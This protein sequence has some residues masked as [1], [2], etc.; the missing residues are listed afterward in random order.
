MNEMDFL[1]EDNPVD[2]TADAAP[3]RIL[4]VD[5]DAGVHRM[6]RWVLKGVEFRERPIE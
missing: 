1:T 6:T 3:W 5:D 4:I 2:T